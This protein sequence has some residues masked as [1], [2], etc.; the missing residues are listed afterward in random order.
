MQIPAQAVSLLFFNQPAP[1]RL[2]WH[3]SLEELGQVHY[4][5]RTELWLLGCEH[6][7]MHKTSESASF[8]HQIKE[9]LTV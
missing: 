8:Q 2:R 4:S 9:C 3:I 1:L 5:R 7:L 6:S